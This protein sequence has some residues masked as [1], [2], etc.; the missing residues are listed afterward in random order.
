MSSRTNRTLIA[1]GGHEDKE[2]GR[3]V[4]KEVA[5]QVG[6]GKLVVTT[7]ASEEPAGLFE[8]Y[9]QAFRDLGV[10]RIEHLRIDHRADGADPDRVRLLADTKGVFF[11][12]GDQLKITSQIGDTPVFQ[13]IARLYHRGAVVAGTSSG[14]AVLCETMIVSGD[15]DASHKLGSVLRMAPGLGLVGGVI[16]DMHFAE[17]GRMG[18]LIGAVAQNPRVIGIGIDED[19]AIVLRNEVSFSVLGGGA[20]YVVDG[21]PVTDSNISEGNEDETLAIYDL[22]L[23]VLSTGHE[24]ALETRRPH[25]EGEPPPL[26]ISSA[27]PAPPAEAPAKAVTH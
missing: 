18:R 2:R 1:V 14:A 17:R 6:S 7:V 10:R 19:T 11:T 12:G 22:K 24:F 13:T 25:R 3:E 26:E 27:R 23:H 16:I 4:L 21:Q 9:R 8:E 5:R 15:G 20:V